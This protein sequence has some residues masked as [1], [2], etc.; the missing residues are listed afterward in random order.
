MT[1]AV[2]DDLIFR[3][4]LDAALGEQIVIVT[5]IEAL[6]EQLR[7]SGWTRVIIDLHLSSMDSIEAIRVVRSE[8][9]ELPVIAYGS[10]VD[11]ARRQQAIAAGCHAVLARSEMVQ[12]MAEWARA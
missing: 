11:V 8:Q 9:P 12:Q 2:I 5:T 10:H 3:S 1:L 4:K 7:Q 6:H